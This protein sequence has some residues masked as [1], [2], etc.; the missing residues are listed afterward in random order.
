MCISPSYEHVCVQVPGSCLQDGCTLRRPNLVRRLAQGEE[1]ERV[2][3]RTNTAAAAPCSKAPTAAAVESCSLVPFEHHA[4]CAAGH[5]I[6]TE[7]HMRVHLDIG[8]PLQEATCRA[9]EGFP[10]AIKPELHWLL[11]ADE[12]DDLPAARFG[13]STKKTLLLPPTHL[14]TH[15]NAFTNRCARARTCAR[16]N[17]YKHT[18]THTQTNTLTHTHTHTYAHTTTHTHATHP[19]THTYTHTVWVHNFWLM[20]SWTLPASMLTK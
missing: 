2:A 13:K 8:P 18:H 20:H 4:L 1:S 7:A 5:G 11:T 6:R 16:N 17:T 3:P 14:Q 9:H 19:R 15:P 12:H 10:T